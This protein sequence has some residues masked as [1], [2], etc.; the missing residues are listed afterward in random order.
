MALTFEALYLT[1]QTMTVELYPVATDVIANGAGG[2]SLT[3]STNAKGRYTATVAETLSG[4]HY[5]TVKSGSVVLRNGYA[6]L[7]DGVT[8]RVG[9]SG[10]VDLDRVNAEVLDVFA[11]DTYAEPGQGAPAATTTLA[12][13][14]NYLYKW[15]RNKKDQTATQVRYYADNATTVDHK[16][17][18]SDDGTTTVV[19][20]IE[21]GP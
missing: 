21:T 13:K 2:D 4:W 7:T 18:V 8:I 9:E 3:E 10:P 12:A 15:A 20:E 1:G 17:T 5:Y 14:L 16:A 19:D 11:T 6:Y